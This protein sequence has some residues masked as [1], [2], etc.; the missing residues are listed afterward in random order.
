VAIAHKAKAFDLQFI[1]N[2]A[3]QMKW[4]PEIILNGLKILSVKIEHMLLIDSVSYLPKPLRKFPEA[5]VLSVTK[6]W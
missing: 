5:F 2:R 1:L 6:S 4:K 3:I